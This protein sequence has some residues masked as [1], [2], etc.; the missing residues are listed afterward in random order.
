MRS[1]NHETLKENEYMCIIQYAL[2][3]EHMSIKRKYR[4]KRLLLLQE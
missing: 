2:R 1:Q 3:L 4:T